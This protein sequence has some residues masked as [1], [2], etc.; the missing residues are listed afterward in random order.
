VTEVP[1]P[2]DTDAVLGVFVDGVSKVE[3]LDYDVED[4][5]ASGSPCASRAT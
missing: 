5:S 4:R 2:S 3:G 1:L